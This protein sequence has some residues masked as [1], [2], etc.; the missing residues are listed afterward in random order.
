MCLDIKDFYSCIV[1]FLNLYHVEFS[2]TCF[3]FERAVEADPG[4]VEHQVN[5]VKC[6]WRLKDRRQECF[7]ALLKV[8]RKSAH[9]VDFFEIQ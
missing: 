2:Y 6:L 4:N 1:L 9:F 5:L 8:Y 7:T 3:R